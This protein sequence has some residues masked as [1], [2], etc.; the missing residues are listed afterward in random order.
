MS[1]VLRVACFTALALAACGDADPAPTVE[2]RAAAPDTLVPADDLRD[3]LV[4]TIGYADA[5]ADLGTGIAAIHD[6][7]AAGLVTTLTLPTIASEEAIAAGVPITGELALQLTDVGAVSPQ[8]AAPTL[9]ADLGAPPPAIG[10]A[11]FCVV[12][13]D[14]AGHTGPGD[15]TAPIAIAP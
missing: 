2:I 12:L 11:T 14:A 3:D 13:T 1:P 15:C 9:C 10:V 6:C 5:D 4:I 8:A 7:R